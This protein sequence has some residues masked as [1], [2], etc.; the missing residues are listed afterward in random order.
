MRKHPSS[1]TSLYLRQRE[2][3]A[4]KNAAL[5]EDVSVSKYVSRLLRA[6]FH[7]EKEERAVKAAAL[8]AS[9]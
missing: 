8:G 7:L 5:K 4:L 2:V 1:I 6:H 3:R 9:L